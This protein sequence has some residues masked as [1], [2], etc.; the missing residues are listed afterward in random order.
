MFTLFVTSLAVLLT[1]TVVY[2]EIEADPFWPLWT[3]IIWITAAILIIVSLTAMTTQEYMRMPAAPVK[4]VSHGPA[5]KPP[6]EA[7]V[8]SN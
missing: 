8:Q 1:T 4:V 5:E 6:S 7:K 2:A 3:T